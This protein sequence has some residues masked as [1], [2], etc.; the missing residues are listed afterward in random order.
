MNINIAVRSHINMAR[1]LE[2]VGHD[3]RTKAIGKL[4]TTIV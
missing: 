4:Q 3:Y 1:V 2:T